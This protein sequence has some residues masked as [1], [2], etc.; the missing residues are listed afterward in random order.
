MT[1]AMHPAIGLL[2]SGKCYVY[3]DGCGPDKEPFFGT[4][5]Q[6][7]EALQRRERP[8]VKKKKRSMREYLV[9]YIVDQPAYAGAARYVDSEEVMFALDRNDALR[10]GREVIRDCGGKF[11]PKIRIRARLK[12]LE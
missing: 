5:A 9:T 4:Q 6:C 8:P 1:T 12:P 10:K 11:G 2:S 7:E 3:L